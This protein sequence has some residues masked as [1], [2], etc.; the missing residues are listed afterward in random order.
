MHFAVKWLNSQVAGIIYGAFSLIF[1]WMTT[2]AI[3]LYDTFP[4]YF[5]NDSLVIIGLL[6]A[7]SVICYLLFVVINGYYVSERF[8]NAF[9]YTCIICSFIYIV[10]PL[11][12]RP[13]SIAF[14][15]DFV[16]SIY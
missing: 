9:H 15:K 16:S 8:K 2:N 13:S 1:L 4:E 3:T 11:Y 6:S 5:A 14:V 12:A 10:I 7:A